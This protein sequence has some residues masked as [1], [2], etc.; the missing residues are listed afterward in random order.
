MF[1]CADDAD[2]LHLLNEALMQ[3]ARAISLIGI[4]RIG[5][6]LTVA[7]RP[8]KEYKGEQWAYEFLDNLSD[9]CGQKLLQEL[10]TKAISKLLN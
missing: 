9:S 4:R 2:R 10:G 1:I 5:K 7:S 3:G 8:F 6:Q